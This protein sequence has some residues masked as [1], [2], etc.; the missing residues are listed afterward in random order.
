MNMPFVALS[1]NIPLLGVL[2][3]T[4]TLEPKT[5]KCLTLGFLSVHASYWVQ[6]FKDTSVANVIRCCD[7]FCPE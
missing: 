6:T 1:W 2:S 3:V 7:G 5:R 4:K